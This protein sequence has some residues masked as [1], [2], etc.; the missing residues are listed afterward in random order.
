[1]IESLEG[2]VSALKSKLAKKI[3]DINGIN[4][5]VLKMLG[6]LAKELKLKRDISFKKVL[7]DINKYDGN[8]IKWKELLYSLQGHLGATFGK[9]ESWLVEDVR[10]ILR[11]VKEGEKGGREGGWEEDEDGQSRGGDEGEGG[12]GS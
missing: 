1:M 8:R 7:V 3:Y 5:A 10:E 9:S 11:I 2:T 4:Y 12:G 6:P